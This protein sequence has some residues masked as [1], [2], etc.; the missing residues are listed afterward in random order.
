M[1]I[2]EGVSAHCVATSGL[3]KRR[4]PD[5]VYNWLNIYADEGFDGLIRRRHG[6]ARHRFSK[7]EELIE[8]LRQSPGEVAEKVPK[9]LR[10]RLRRVV[11]RFVGFVK[12]LIG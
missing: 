12:V 6:G 1:K 8:R 9:V 10:I 5:T 4:K 7:K 11:G 2:A 3:L